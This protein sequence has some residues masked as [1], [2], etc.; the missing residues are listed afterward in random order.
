MTNYNKL[1]YTRAEAD[2][3]LA[4]ATDQSNTLA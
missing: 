1:I 3:L 4:L 2:V